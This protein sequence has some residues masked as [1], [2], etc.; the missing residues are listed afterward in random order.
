[1]KRAKEKQFEVMLRLIKISNVILITVPFVAC[2]FGYYA[3]RTYSPYFAKGNYLIVILFA[4]MY[5]VF[6][7]V[8]DGFQV[9]IMRISE[10]VYSQALA[11]LMTDGVFYVICC[12]LTKHWAAFWP[13]FLVFVSQ[14]ALSALWGTAAHRW[15]FRKFPQKD[16][17]IVYDRYEGL[18]ELLSKYGFDIKFNVIRTISTSEFREQGVSVLSDA[19][20]VFTA[21]IPSHDRNIILKYCVKNDIAAYMIPKI[22]DLLVSSSKRVHMLN[23]PVLMTRRYNPVFEYVVIK[24]L[25][26]I[27]ISA[28]ALIV[29]SP[30]FLITS[31]AIKAC[32]KG[33]VFYKQCRLTRDGK[34]FNILKFRSMRVNA[35][36]DGIA[37]LSTGEK[38]DRITPVGRIIRMLRIDE[39]PQ[40]VNI[41]KGDMSIVGP[42]PE[43]P[44]IAEQYEKELPEFSLRLQVKA[45]LTGSAQVYGKYNTTPADKLKMDLMYISR[46][47]LM[48]DLR[49][50]FATIKI[51]FMKDSTEGVEEGQVTAKIEIP[52]TEKR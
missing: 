11:E 39:L 29:L 14:I 32:D 21:G 52:N 51:L 9:Q 41:L 31:I 5:F 22:G 36:K 19:E 44:E 27:I 46:P 20:A 28:L 15:Y 50:I 47:S 25:F 45:G 40:L 38:D 37:R 42:R 23:L 13:I 30:V 26:D 10:I 2:W 12:L 3:E 18:Q 16:T 48:E 34:K 35:E 6:G 24:R 17:V 33:P 8:Y 7:R 4:F 1:M 43:R 49:I